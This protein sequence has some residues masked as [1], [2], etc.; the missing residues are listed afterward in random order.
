MWNLSKSPS[1]VRR[2]APLLGEHNR[3]V[4]CGY[5]GLSEDELAELAERRV[6]Y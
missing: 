5:L 3:E 4:L 6:V 1:R 2:H